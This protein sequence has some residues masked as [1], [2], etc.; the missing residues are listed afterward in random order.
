MGCIL[1]YRLDMDAKFW[2]CHL[3]FISLMDLQGFPDFFILK[4]GALVVMVLLFLLRLEV[5][6][7]V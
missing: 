4:G 3:P 5:V 6:C 1:F 2:T 7:M